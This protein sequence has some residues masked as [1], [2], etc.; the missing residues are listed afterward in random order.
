MRFFLPSVLTLTVTL[1]GAP[2]VPAEPPTEAKIES[3]LFDTLPWEAK[4][5]TYETAMAPY[6]FRWN[7]DLKES[8]RSIQPGMTLFGHPVNE[9]IIRFKD[10]KPSQITASF[11][12]RGDMGTLSNRNFEALGA[13]LAGKIENQLGRKPESI[14][15]LRARSRWDTQTLLWNQEPSVFRLELSQTKVKSTDTLR[16][17]FIL[18]TVLPF[19]NEAAFSIEDRK[20]IQI[21]MFSLREK[22]EKMPG[23]GV[24]L[25]GLPMVDQGKKG[26]CATASVERILRYYG[27][28]V[29]QHELAQ[30]ANTQRMGTMPDELYEALKSISTQFEFEVNKLEMLELDDYLDLI[31]D[32]NKEAKKED[33]RPYQHGQL[34]NIAEM[35]YTMDNDLLKEVRLDSNMKFKQFEKRIEDNLEEGVPLLWGVMLGVIEEPEIPQ[36]LGGHMRIIFG[37]DPKEEEILYTDS[38]G[39]GHEEKRMSLEDA[40]VITTSLFAI[41]SQ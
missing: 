33:K 12:N 31:K 36:A 30:Y 22:V 18:L 17:E 15:S 29:T 1:I 35:Y 8:A 25:K 2:S 11:Y 4:R 5:V 41:S 10:D 38:W 7:S 3:L 6:G 9:L 14:E 21:D 32:Y 34:I 19:T 37:Y 20:K 16:P 28:D 13:A 27:A 39:K 40:F 23:G 26:Y 24:R